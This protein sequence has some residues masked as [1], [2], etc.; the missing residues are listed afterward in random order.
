[1]AGKNLPSKF[2]TRPAIDLYGGG[3][4]AMPTVQNK[5]IKMGKKNREGEAVIRDNTPVKVAET[6]SIDQ[7]ISEAE[8]SA[9]SV[10]VKA[11]GKYE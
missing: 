6:A 7:R 4:N 1:M 5:P 10:K 9:S 2:E 8:Q 3:S 11:R